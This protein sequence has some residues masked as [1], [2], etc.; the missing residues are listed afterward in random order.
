[1]DTCARTLR[2]KLFARKHSL[3]NHEFEK[4]VIA[5]LSATPKK[6]SPKYLY[7]ANGSQLF[8]EICE[9][10]EYYPTRTERVILEEYANEIASCFSDLPVI[11][12]LGSGSSVKTKLIIESFLQRFGRLHYVPIDISKSI[13][14][15]SSR[16]LLNRYKKLRITALASEYIA[17]LDRIRDK[18]S[19]K[20][21]IFLGSSIGNF[22][23]EERIDFLKRV[24]EDMGA[25]DHL[26]MGMDLIKE[27]SILEPAYDDASGV[28]AK[29]NTNLIK[30]I[31]RELEG[32]FEPKH[33]KHKAFL[34]EDLGR[35][36]MHLESTVSQKVSINNSENTFTFEKGE[37]IHTENSYKF[38][39]E[40]LLE[41]ADRVVVERGPG[42][43]LFIQQCSNSLQQLC[44]HPY[45]L[46][47]QSSSYTVCRCG[48]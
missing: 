27:K 20:L 35:I 12:E 11:V 22:D 4:D 44:R 39:K 24:R 48:R 16:K 14:I 1:M 2:L 31:N 38:T 46:P 29:F 32:N 5:G 3:N 9:L 10:P 17:A 34:N 45:L 40:Q 7:D 18:I 36:E 25:N 41:I 8:E 13:L 47:V 28:T 33:F 37:T 43:L 26:L 21:I 23:A 6:L 42:P 19:N 30:R 15:E